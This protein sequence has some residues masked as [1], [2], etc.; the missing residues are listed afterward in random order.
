MRP[1]VSSIGVAFG[2]IDGSLVVLAFDIN[3]VGVVELELGTVIVS[4]T[5]IFVSGFPTSSASIHRS[6]R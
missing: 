2:D 5:Q 1:A 3:C 4:L 6:D